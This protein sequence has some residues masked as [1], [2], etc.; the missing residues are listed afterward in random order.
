[1]SI[2]VTL[3]GDGS[4]AGAAA[5]IVSYTVTEDA[6]SLNLSDTQG[7][8]GGIEFTV[9]EDDSF[10]GSILLPGEPFT[11]LDPRA[12]I[13]AG[14][15]DSATV[16]NGVEL[17][18]TGST[19]LLPLVSEHVVP[20]FSGTLGGAILYYASLC[21]IS[22]GI[23]LDPIIAV[24][25]VALPSFTGEVWLQIK[26]LAAVHQFE[27]AAVGDAII[28][29]Q[30][31]LRSVDVQKYTNTRFNF[32]NGQAARTVEVHYY[33]N[34]WKDDEQ[35]YP[36]P[37][38]SILDRN[39]IS[40]GAGETVVTNVPL[41]MWVG[42]IDPP[43]QV[44]SLPWDNTSATSVYAVVDK[45]G[46]PVSVTDWQNAGG[47]MT[48]E[49]GADGKSIDVTVRGAATNERA[50]YRIASSS[51]DM[52]YQYA[53]LYIAASGV[54]F[55]NEMIS[56]GTG[57]NEETLPVDSVHTIDEPVVS[58]LH[59]AHVVMAN[60]VAALSGLSQTLEATSTA[61]N[62]RGE[63]GQI[64]YPTFE[65]FNGNYVG[66]A[67]FDEFNASLP[68]DMTFD[69]FN[70]FL[71]TMVENDFETQAFGSISGARVRYRDAMY[72]IT[73]ATSSPGQFVWQA[74]L[75]TTFADWEEV[76]GSADLTFEQFNAIWEGKTFEQHAR[77]PL[78]I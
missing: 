1:M 68:P 47:L 14:L 18:V 72:R 75:D 62:R 30:P 57:A 40:V 54:A 51:V 31:R 73:S 20:A 33:N 7:G 4:F 13:L 58:T 66:E 78:Y 36:D 9:I 34:E 5:N 76:Y 10:D 45:E 50:P 25:S 3:D 8:V 55:K 11:L 6:T 65:W 60:A 77:Q 26:K 69:E 49:I 2:Q 63:T 27:I 53:A 15:V 23:Q 21:G 16:S 24:K 28:I 71:A 38:S 48:L 74:E 42:T 19:A 67:T 61:V 32:G 43:S 29:R 17:G 39:I 70:S 59:D 12:G 52:E 46:A 37:E 22:S 56:S 41:D 35:V 64:A 44:L